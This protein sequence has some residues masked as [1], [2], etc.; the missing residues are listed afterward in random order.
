M[1]SSEPVYGNDNAKLK[2]HSVKSALPVPAPKCN[3]TSTGN[4]VV[5]GSLVYTCHAGYIGI[6]S[7]PIIAWNGPGSSETELRSKAVVVLRAA[8]SGGAL[9]SCVFSLDLPASHT[10]ENENV[11]STYNCTSASLGPACRYFAVFL[12]Q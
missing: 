6:E 4:L 9:V 7:A 1:V 3:V 12:W 8:R 11:T 5:E 10:D 2:P